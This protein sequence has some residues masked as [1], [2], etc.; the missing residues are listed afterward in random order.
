MEGRP[1]SEIKFLST[2]AAQRSE[3]VPTGVR[4][5][6]TMGQ[7]AIEAGISKSTLSRAI[8]TGRL[9]AVRNDKGGFDIDP[10]ELFRVYPRNGATSSTNS[11]MTRGATAIE[12]AT[13]TGE[14]LALRAEIDGLKAQLDMM[15]EYT[16]EQLTELKGQRDAWQHQAEASQRLLADQR[17]IRRSGWFGLGRAS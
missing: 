10:A 5:M 17:P 1:I 6:L 11:A 4:A 12:P 9:S 7:A 3:T 8:K 15:R 14:T 2:I 13:A 16:S